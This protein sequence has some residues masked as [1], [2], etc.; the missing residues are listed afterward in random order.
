M[1]LA[2][3]SGAALC[4][5]LGLLL[6]IAHFASLRANVRLYLGGRSRVP[7]VGLHL[8]R[9]L[10]VALAWVLLARL[11]GPTGV[12]AALAGFLVA[13]PLCTRDGKKTPS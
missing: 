7:A 2:A 4:A 11:G 10:F 8:A 12:V 9:L 1:T 13:R 5:I 3:V 6:G